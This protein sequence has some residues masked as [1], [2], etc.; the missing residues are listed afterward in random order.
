MDGR[1]GLLPHAQHLLSRQI[2]GNALKTPE[3]FP[4]K[5]VRLLNMKEQAIIGVQRKCS[6]SF[7][8]A[9]ALLLTF[10]H[11]GVIAQPAPPLRGFD[12]N[13]VAFVFTR[14]CPT[15]YSETNY[16]KR[17]TCFFVFVPNT[18]V[19]AQS[20]W[21]YGSF[22]I[23]TAKHVLF[24]EKG[25]QLTPEVFIRSPRKEGGLSYSQL[26]LEPQN[27]NPTN[28]ITEY[29]H[30]SRPRIFTHSDESVDL[31]VIEGVPDPTT[32][33]LHP[34]EYTSLI[35]RNSIKD[36]AISPG[37][38]MFFLGMFT[39][40]VGSMDN[41]PVFRFGHLSMLAAE[42]IPWSKE[43]PAQDLFLM[44][45]MCFGGN[46]GGPVFFFFDELRYP[47]GPRFPLAGTLKGG[48]SALEPLQVIETQA[49]PAAANNMGITAVVPAYYIKEILDCPVI[50]RDRNRIE[51]RF[52]AREQK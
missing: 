33:K 51:P 34:I 29:S 28:D 20:S 37:D 41:Y 14:N 4:C 36:F 13:V 15:N 30:I 39:P 48:W 50:K 40:F 42:K 38:Q 21:F 17:G 18:N 5:T 22:Y 23:V 3:H 12:K 47:N 10:I 1:G 26:I 31:A 16:V 7:L 52:S 45:A 44:D 43:E 25:K 35:E 8:A 11:Y 19:P 24:S 27:V 2:A 46:S 49:T 6:T 9:I 32:L